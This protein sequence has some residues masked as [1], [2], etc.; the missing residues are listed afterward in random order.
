MDALSFAGALDA[1]DRLLDEGGGGTVFTPN[2]DHVVISDRDRRLRDAYQGASLAVPDGQWLVWASR[3]LGTPL[4]EKISGSDL[5]VPLARRAAA[6]RRRIYLLGA[7]PGVAEEAG[8]RLAA[9]TDVRI[10][11]C[12]SPAIALDGS[13]DDR[14]RVLRPIQDARPDIVLVALGAPK[15][16]IWIHRNASALRPSVLFG[17]GASLDFIAGRVRR[18]PRWISRAGL[19]WLF[20]LV[21]EPRRL[22]RRY[23]LNDPKFLAILLRTSREP[24]ESRVR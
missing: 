18:A 17:V 7:P 6:R 10:A 14:E 12:S 15:Q 9:A 2:V 24:R 8:R 23:L 5:V 16:E 1:I 3:L 11:G 4:P 21:L 22:A 19:E 13:A 20:R